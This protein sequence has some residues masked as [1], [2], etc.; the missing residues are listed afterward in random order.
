MYL[1]NHNKQRGKKNKPTIII[2][3]KQ[4][5]QPTGPFYNNFHPVFDTNQARLSKGDFHGNC[6][7]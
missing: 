1:K 2:Q 6:K 5:K 7:T 4:E 3:R